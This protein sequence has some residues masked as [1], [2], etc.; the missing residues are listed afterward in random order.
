[1]SAYDPDDNSRRCYDLAIRAAREKCIR[2][3]QILPDHS[4]PDEV[5]WADE[6]PR[7]PNELEAVR[8]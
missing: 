3:G 8:G 2:S 6:G 1:M 5:R 4:K 7:A